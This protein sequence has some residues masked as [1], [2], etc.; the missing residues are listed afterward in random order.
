MQDSRAGIDDIGQGCPLDRLL[1]FL[2]QAWM[3]DLV[4]AL[5]VHGTLHFG[6]LRRVLGGRVSPRVLA[7]RLRQ[8]QALGLVSRAQRPDGRREVAYA[9]TSDGHLLNAALRQVEAAL[10]QTRLPD[11]IGPRP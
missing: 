7:L 6:A 11:A 3:A 8:L 2:A 10:R 5:G 9:L 1:G 4:W